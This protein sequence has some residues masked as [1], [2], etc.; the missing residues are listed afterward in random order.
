MFG[1]GGCRQEARHAENGDGVAGPAQS[2]T[3][4]KLQSISEQE[5]VFF[6]FARQPAMQVGLAAAIWVAG[7]VQRSA[8]YWTKG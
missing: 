3:G 1:G 2:H 5:P 6:R 8:M 4:Q 7:S